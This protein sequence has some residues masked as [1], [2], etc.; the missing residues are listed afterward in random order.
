MP[1]PYSDN[2]YSMSDDDADVDA[3]AGAADAQQDVDALSPADGYF[4]GSSSD[5]A[6]SP[7]GLADESPRRVPQHLHHA[8]VPSVP[9][10]MVEDPTLRDQ[11]ASAKAREAEEERRLLN[12]QAASSPAAAQPR[13]SAPHQD[14]SLPTQ[15]HRRA[16]EDDYAPA[17]AHAHASSSSS[18]A[19]P[20]P[21]T[22]PA[23]APPSDAPPAYSPRSPTSPTSPH[24]SVSGYQT[25]G[26]APQSPGMGA[27]EEQQSLLQREPQ[28][29][30]APGGH[31][32]GSLWQRFKGRMPA[33]GAARAKI[34]RILGVLLVISIVA[35]ILGSVSAPS[36]SRSH[37][38]VS[39]PG[40]S[41]PS[42]H[43]PLAPLG[44]A[45]WPSAS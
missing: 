16:V 17:H 32:G 45:L 36:T 25:F 4:H 42:I 10:V 41:S 5:P 15:H 38:D 20:A 28:S 9:N 24:A 34:R 12:S 11:D 35:A 27:A 2:L 1:V 21:H 44:G 30:G 31:P 6:S 18:A 8:G 26:N 22:L 7:H 40:P 29:M 37:R 33:R 3:G 39:Y 23:P 13:Q 19:A 43:P 14:P